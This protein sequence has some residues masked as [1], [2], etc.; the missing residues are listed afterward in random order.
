VYCKIQDTRINDQKKDILKQFKNA[1]GK[2]M[3]TLSILI[4]YLSQY[5]ISR[6]SLTTTRV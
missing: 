4:S 3:F 6:Q 2:E 5:F 1:F